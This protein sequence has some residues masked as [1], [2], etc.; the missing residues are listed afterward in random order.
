MRYVIPLHLMEPGIDANFLE[1]IDASDDMPWCLSSFPGRPIEP[2]VG[3]RLRAGGRKRGF[4]AGKMTDLVGSDNCLHRPLS[5]SF[6][7]RCLPSGIGA[8]EIR[9]DLSRIGGQKVA[10]S[11]GICAVRPVLLS[12]S[13]ALLSE[14]IPGLSKV[15]QREPVIRKKAYIRQS[16][17]PFLY[18][19]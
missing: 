12:C 6:A 8:A 19:S 16:A 11:P 3:C 1:E 17:Q 7:R 9:G 15:C 10:P 14:R 4:V 13:I 2:P 18:L 5:G